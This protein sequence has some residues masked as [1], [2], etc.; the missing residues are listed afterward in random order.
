MFNRFKTSLFQPSKIAGFQKD[1]KLTTFLYYII[2]ALL[3]TI[4]S[5][6]LIFSTVGLDYQDKQTIRNELRDIEIPYEIKEHKLIKNVEN[7]NDY[8]Q[9]K[10][11]ET[12]TLIFTELDYEAVKFNPI[13]VGSLIMLTSEEVV[14]HSQFFDV[15]RI[16]Y[17]DYEQIKNI[18]LNGAT[19]NDSEFW[20]TVFPIVNG[21]LV[22]YSPKTRI[23]NSVIIL[24]AQAFFLMLFS[25]LVAFFQ[26]VK[27]AS[28]LSFGKIWQLT[29]YAMTPYVIITLFG[30]LYG[31]GIFAYM[32]V[33]VSYIYANRMSYT[34]L[35]K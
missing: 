27:L 34:L 21:L 26:R 1:S 11:S 13:H 6:I 8:Y 3:A 15:I 14:Y 30:D 20:N 7:D 35:K 17:S 16:K 18:N 31:L 19:T 12:V 23:V 4:P 28:I 24:A 29:I 32:G 5:I 9:I 25:L 33:F 2:L 22:E 10:L